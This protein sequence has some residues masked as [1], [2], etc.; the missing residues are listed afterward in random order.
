MTDTLNKM[1]GFEDKVI[2]AAIKEAACVA[3]AGTPAKERFP[4]GSDLFPCVFRGG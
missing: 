2:Q 1:N 3:F 4:L